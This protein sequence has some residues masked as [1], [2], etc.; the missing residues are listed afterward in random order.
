MF[1]GR[2]RNRKRYLLGVYVALALFACAEFHG[3]IPLLGFCETHGIPAHG[4][5]NDPLRP[6]TQQPCGLCV[7]VQSLV[8]TSQWETVETPSSDTAYRQT[9]PDYAFFWSD[10]SWTPESLRGP[11]QIHT[12]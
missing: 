7:L 4:S 12:S 8:L 6:D 5:S 10:V 2:I 9:L 1:P 3:L 11:P